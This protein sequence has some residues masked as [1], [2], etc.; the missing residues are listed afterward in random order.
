MKIRLLSV[1]AILV[2]TSGQMPAFAADESFDI[3]RFRVEGNTIL[4]VADVGQLVAPFTGRQRTYAD[5]QRALEALEGAYRNR[6]FGAVQVYVPEQELT[7]GVVTLQVTEAVIGRVVVNGNQYF[8]TE[9]VR[10][11]LPLLKEGMAP[12]LRQIS[13]NVQLA[14]E[15]PAKQVDVSLAASD[16]EGK[17]DAK[18]QVEDEAP[19]KVI[20]T[21]DNTGDKD[22]TGQYRTGFAYRD[23]NLMGS[24]EVLTLGYITAPDA[25]E[26]VGMDVYSLGLRIPF[27]DQGDSLD[28]IYANSSV[29]LPANVIQPGGLLAINGKGDIWAVRWNHL[30]PR[31]G[32]YTSRFVTGFDQKVSLN[33]C[34]TGVGVSCV[35][36]TTRLLSGT[37]SGQWATSRFTADFNAGIAYSIPM[38]GRQDGWRYNYASMGRATNMDFYVLKAGGS[39]AMAVGDWMVRA[40]VVTQ[41]SDKPLPSGEQLGLAGANAVRG[42]TERAQAADVGYVA[43]VELYTPDLIPV[44]NKLSDQNV[45]GILRALAFIDTSDGYNWLTNGVKYIDESG[46]ANTH[47]ATSINERILLSSFGFGLRYG[48]GKDISAKF[49]WAKVIHSAPS[50]KTNPADR[51]DADWRAHFSISYAF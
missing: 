32:E 27:Y 26:G 28:I 5:V 2:M 34:T 7:E 6:G 17:V 3:V 13:E 30:M 1:L 36:T 46:A 20:L 48:I 33:S 22:K 40:A 38:G 15:N 9:N 44:I 35:N 45:L 11:T 42:F 47:D 49:D 14:N 25:P 23:S 50:S 39:Y 37:Y 41:Y 24:D 10:R 29:N 19:R 8:S 16:E 51:I 18:V 21:L 12:N 4:P 43:N 31:E